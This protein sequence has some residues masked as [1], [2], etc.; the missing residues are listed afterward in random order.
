VAS[1]LQ[2]TAR[3]DPPEHVSIA[4]LAGNSQ[5]V[6]TATRSRVVVGARARNTACSAL[7]G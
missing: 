6:S 5:R 7:V 2:T 4:C 1:A 3:E